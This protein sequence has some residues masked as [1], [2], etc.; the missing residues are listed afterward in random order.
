MYIVTLNNVDE[1]D[2]FRHW[3]E[4]TIIVRPSCCDCNFNHFSGMK[5]QWTF[6]VLVISVK[7]L[8]WY[9]HE[10]KL[11]TYFALTT[12]LKINLQHTIFYTKF[13]IIIISE[14]L[15]QQQAVW[16][17]YI[18]QNV[19]DNRVIIHSTFHQYHYKRK[20]N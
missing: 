10:L 18:R 4:R 20:K 11:K 17:L 15:L 1:S 7:I 14:R 5:I 9:A 8:P 6:C 3:V 12:F 2:P 19:V 13:E 16:V